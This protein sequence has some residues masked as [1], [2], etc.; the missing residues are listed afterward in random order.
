MSLRGSI[1]GTLSLVSSRRQELS[2]KESIKHRAE[3]AE[4]LVVVDDWLV[5]VV[6]GRQS[7]HDSLLVVVRP[8]TR[9]RAPHYT[10]LHRVVAHL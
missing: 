2:I 7:S 10:R 6:E 8:V 3:F 9:R 4:F 1:T 5:E